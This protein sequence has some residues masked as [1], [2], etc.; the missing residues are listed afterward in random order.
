MALGVIAFNTQVNADHRLV[1]AVLHDATG[2]QVGQMVVTPH[3]G[4][5]HV[6]VSVSGLSPASDFHGFHIHANNDPSNGDGCVAPA[7]TSADGHYT[8]GTGTHGD[9]AGDMPVLYAQRNGSAQMSFV[10]DAYRPQD[11]VGRAVIVHAGR[12]NYGNVPVGANPDQYTANSAAATTL[13]ENTGNAGARVVC[14]VL[15]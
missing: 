4:G 7:F 10:T 12:N 3:R 9:H 6:S 5:S 13:T 11:V 14:G 15:K 1:K 2:R 8:S